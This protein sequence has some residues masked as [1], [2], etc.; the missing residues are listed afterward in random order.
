MTLDSYSPAGSRDHSPP[1]DPCSFI[2]TEHT[3]NFFHQPVLS[4]PSAYHAPP[5]IPVM[6]TTTQMKFVS[7]ANILSQQSVAPAAQSVIV[8][9][10]PPTLAGLRVCSEGV[11]VCG[12][13]LLWCMW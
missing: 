3:T 2:R 8:D 11:S 5:I 6:G 10:L 12:D 13:G 4:M 7:A 9:R 1:V